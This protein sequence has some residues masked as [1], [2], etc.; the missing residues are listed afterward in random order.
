M[1][2]LESYVYNLETFSTRPHIT[3]LGKIEREHAG[4]SCPYLEYS[5][6][7]HL[8]FI[9]IEH[10]TNKYFL[11]YHNRNKSNFIV[12]PYPSY[13]HHNMNWKGLKTH[14]RNVFMLLAAGTRKSN[15]F[16]VKVSNKTDCNS[17]ASEL[18]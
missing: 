7:Q 10:E 2:Q 11:Q 4:Q 9:G 5:I 15:P 1:A 12:A 13:V 8:T 16:R 18:S 14:N 17:L 6:T 3:T